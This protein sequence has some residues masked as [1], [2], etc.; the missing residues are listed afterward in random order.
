MTPEFNE[1]IYRLLFAP[2]PHE[3]AMHA[4]AVLD[5]AQTPEIVKHIYALQPEHVCLYTGDLEPDIIEV[6]PY[7]VRLDPEAEFTAWLVEE[8][9]GKS[10]A[11]FAQTPHDLRGMRKHFRSL[12]TVYDPD[13]EPLLFRFYDPRV[14]R[15]FLPT[16]EGEE[17]QTMFGAIERYIVEAEDPASALRFRR[18]SGAL[19][20]DEIA[21]A[22]VGVN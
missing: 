15:L 14:L 16:C 18:Q 9:W 13:N 1:A 8:G 20:Q 19:K 2:A 7:L 4:Y 10:W 3:E 5:G 11:I 6:A 12:T 21:L 17:L 22:S